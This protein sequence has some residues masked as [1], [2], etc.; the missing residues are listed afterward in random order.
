ML[1]SFSDLRPV[2]CGT[3]DRVINTLK[4]I[5]IHKKKVLT[6]ISKRMNPNFYR[7]TKFI[8]SLHCWFSVNKR[9][10]EP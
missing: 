4:V 2:R 8:S 5:V 3:E 10:F 7:Y 6:K 1:Q 9:N